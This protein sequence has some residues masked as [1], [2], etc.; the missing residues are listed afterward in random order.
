MQDSFRSGK[1]TY[2][3]LT[4]APVSLFLQANVLLISNMSTAATIL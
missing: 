1:L 4:Y 3:P 2:L